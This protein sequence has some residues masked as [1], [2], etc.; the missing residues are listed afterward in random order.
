MPIQATANQN[1]R[2]TH[3]DGRVTEWEQVIVAVLMDIR[4][5][6]GLINACL[7]CRDTLEMPNLLRKIAVNT[8]RKRKKPNG[9]TSTRP[10]R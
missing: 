10:S 2:V 7:N 9:R 1:W 5:E 6:L 4:R 8:R 3:A